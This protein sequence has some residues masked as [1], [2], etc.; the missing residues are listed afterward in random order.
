M[1]K[2]L[3]ST[4]VFCIVLVG[5]LVK[6]PQAGAFFLDDFLNSFTQKAQPIPQKLSLDSSITLAPDGDINKNGQIDGGDSL[7][8]TY[9]LQNNTA[10]AYSFTSLSTNIP[11]DKIHF[12]HN[13]TGA[14][15]VN[16]SGKTITFP[17][18]R[19]NPGQTL[20]VSFEARVNYDP[21][22]DVT[23][24]TNPELKGSD[25]K[26]IINSARKELKV[27]KWATTMSGVTKNS[28]K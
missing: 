12:I 13:V 7:K 3:I 28:Q 26:L 21:K 20:E 2:T 11:R 4:L 14:T 8:F 23:I 5:F 25:N 16:D 15:S 19:I 9:K 27:K 17:N 1:R 10:V 18:L 24:F 22:T 6:A